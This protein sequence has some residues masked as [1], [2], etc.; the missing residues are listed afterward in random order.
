MATTDWFLTYP[1]E[2]L[3]D[4]CWNLHCSKRLTSRIEISW[5]C[6]D[7]KSK[8]ATT[9]AILF[10][11]V[12]SKTVRA[13]FTRFHMGLFV[14]RILTICSNGSVPLNKMAAMSIY[15]KNTSPS[16][17]LRKLWG[18]IL[19][20]S[21]RDSRSTNY[22]QMMILGWPLTFLLQVKNHFLSA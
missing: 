14:E 1:P 4:L 8:M 12:F 10:L 2:Q 20:Y 5:D 18:W 6:A 21:I 22:V 7:R 19:V 17:E 9:A 15:G 11:D 3:G 13:I 16:P